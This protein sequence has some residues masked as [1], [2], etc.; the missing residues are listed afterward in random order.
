MSQQRAKSAPG[1]IGA[2]VM[3]FDEHAARA[4]VKQIVDRYPNDTREQIMLKVRQQVLPKNL[5][6]DPGKYLQSFVDYATINAW[7]AIKNQSATPDAP[8]TPAAPAAPAI[9]LAEVRRDVEIRRTAQQESAKA[10]VKTVLLELLAPNGKLWRDLTIEEYM[11]FGKC[12]MEHGRAM[13][14]AGHPR[15]EL[16]NTAT[17]ETEIQKIFR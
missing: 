14:K 7:R 13:I 1:K 11:T 6:G 8:A 3:S 12:Q 9:K 4:F 17:T 2:K 16:L 10:A 15:T 5:T